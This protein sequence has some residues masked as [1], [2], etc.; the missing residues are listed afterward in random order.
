MNTEERAVKQTRKTVLQGVEDDGHEV[1]W[2]DRYK[3]RKPLRTQITTRW[4]TWVLY[5]YSDGG[6]CWCTSSLANVKR[7]DTSQRWRESNL[8]KLLGLGVKK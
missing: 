3:I 1:V 2:L 7:Q 6:E 5:D 8:A 4:N